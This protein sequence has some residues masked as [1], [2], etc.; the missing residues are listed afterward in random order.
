MGFRKVYFPR[1]PGSPSPLEAR[2]TGRVRFE[3]VDPLGIVWHGRYAGY[4]EDARAEF[5]RRYGLSYSMF[6]EERMAAPVVQMQID[7]RAP[8]F[9]DDI[10]QVQ[11]L[12]NWSDALRLNFEYVITGPVPDGDAGGDAM[13]RVVATA[14]TVQLLTDMKGQV[15]LVESGFM[16][17]FRERWRSGKLA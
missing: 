3:E 11:A 7:F 16:K 9:F 10:F 4:L 15:L 14:C 12:L 2:C 1:E 8:L 17:E 6:M 13:P 5:G